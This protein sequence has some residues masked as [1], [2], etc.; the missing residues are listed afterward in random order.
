[1]NI[2]YADPPWRFEVY[3]ASTGQGR[4]PE[5]HYQTMG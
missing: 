3:D 5:A 1:M 4:A 2:I